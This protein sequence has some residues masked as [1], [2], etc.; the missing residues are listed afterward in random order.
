MWSW[1]KLRPV[2]LS[3]A[4]IRTTSQMQ[5]ASCT[6]TISTQQS[7]VWARGRIWPRAFPLPIVKRENEAVLVGHL[8]KVTG[9]RK[10]GSRAHLLVSISSSRPSHHFFSYFHYSLPHTCRPS[11]RPKRP[12]SPPLSVSDCLPVDASCYVSW[13]WS[14]WTLKI[15]LFFVAAST[16][17]KALHK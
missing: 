10:E 5:L 14:G 4:E 12:P 6:Q 13:L 11:L 7:L 2:R 3:V 15:N 1:L 9:G 8:F 16:S 17:H